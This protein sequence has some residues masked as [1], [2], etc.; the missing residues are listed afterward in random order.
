MI[1][2]LEETLQD[3]QSYLTSAELMDKINEEYPEIKDDP[4]GFED[5]ICQFVL[6]QVGEVFPEDYNTPSVTVVEVIKV[7]GS[8]TE[9][10]STDHPVVKFNGQYYDYTATAFS[11]SYSGLINFDKLPVTQKVLSTMSQV[12]Q[13]VSSVK[14]YALY[15]S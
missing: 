1:K 2:I 5:D 14:S 12:N 6:E 11:D 3:I 15:E 10:L 7:A 9:T 4:S 13:G 8:E